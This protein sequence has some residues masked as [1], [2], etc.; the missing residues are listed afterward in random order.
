M[1]KVEAYVAIEE[2]VREI[3]LKAIQKEVSAITQ[4]VM[5]QIEAGNYAEAERLVSL[6]TL[7]GSLEKRRKN[8]REVLVTALVF[9]QS[10][11]VPAKATALTTGA[12]D[13]PDVLDDGIDQL[14]LLV[15]GQLVENVQKSLRNEIAKAL[16]EDELVPF[17]KAEKAIRINAPDEVGNYVRAGVSTRANLITSRLVSFGFLAQAQRSEITTYQISEVL[18]TRIC[19]VCKYMHGQTFEIEGEIERLTLVLKT[20]NVDELKS[21]A[22]FPSQTKDGLKQLYSMS[23]SQLKAAGFSVPPFHPGCR[24]VVVKAGSVERVFFPSAKEKE[25]G[26]VEVDMDWMDNIPGPMEATEPFKKALKGISQDRLKNAVLGEGVFDKLEWKTRLNNKGIPILKLSGYNSEA[27]DN[28]TRLFNLTDEGLIV[29]HESFKVTSSAQG[30]G[31]AK[32][33]LKSSMALYREL[34]V[35]RVEL[36]ANINVGGYAWAKYGF[37]PTLSE[38]EYIRPT[39]LKRLIDLPDSIQ[40]TLRGLIEGDDPRAIWLLSDS[41]Y[42]KDLLMDT[43]WEGFIDLADDMAMDRFNGYIGK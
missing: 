11:L 37:R 33:L 24:G 4:S 20:K 40:D 7:N 6:F 38:W 19:P 39:L 17:S 29:K 15:E 42:G 27:I 32:K 9:G 30:G 1:A 25:T 35:K 12:M 10:L 16:M 34:G 3:T 36:E 21:L 2:T 22:P 5:G 8:L 28:I 41:P 14:I 43:S 26:E 23:P 31:V 18:D 13:L